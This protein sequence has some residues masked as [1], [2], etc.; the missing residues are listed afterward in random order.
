METRIP[1]LPPATVALPDRFLRAVAHRVNTQVQA[2]R[3]TA[4]TWAPSAMMPPPAKAMALRPV[5]T[6]LLVRSPVAL[7]PAL[8]CL[9]P[10]KTISK[11]TRRRDILPVIIDVSVPPAH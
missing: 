11:M 1:I 9:Y 10:G 4:A 6:L 5:P 7:R 2:V 3:L 8:I